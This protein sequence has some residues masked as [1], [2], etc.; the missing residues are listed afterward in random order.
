[1]WNAVEA[2]RSVLCLVAALNGLALSHSVVT[3]RG[4]RPG[5]SPATYTARRLQL[6]LCAG[7]VVGCAFR[8]ALLVFDI[9]RLV[10]T[11]SWISSV[12]VGRSVATVAELSFA[13]QWALFLLDGARTTGS[14]LMRRVA[15]SVV[16]LIAVAECCSW[17]AVL[18]TNNVGH[19]AEN[20]L[21]GVTAAL[22][23]CSMIAV[24][25]AWHP[26]RHRTL[27]A[28]CVS[29]AVYVAFIFLVDVPGYW[30][31]WLANQASGRHYLTLAQGLQD[32][33]THWVVSHSWQ[34][35]KSEVTWMS[36]YFSVGV[37]VSISLTYVSARNMLT[38]GS[39]AEAGRRRLFM[40]APR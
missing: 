37:W 26:E 20:S 19:V 13:G 17:Y 3:L 15:M 31:R 2:W 1:M 33:S 11:D 4:A 6:L 32:V 25:A 14:R 22:V 5:L 10:L 39:P 16:P 36:L 40:N 8:S 28:W 24:R 21:W 9:P 23:L 27:T 38:A 12:A 7:Y 35:W 29:G 30:A 34:S 18:T